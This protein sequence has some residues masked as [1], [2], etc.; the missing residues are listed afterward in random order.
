MT[1]HGNTAPIH[2]HKGT[3]QG[4]TLSLFLFTIF[5]EPLL[6]W[7]DVGSR[8][9]RPSYQPRKSTTIIIT[10]DDHGYVD[11]VSITAGSIQNL[12]IQLKNSASL[13][14]TPDSN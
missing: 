13:A 11:D 3:L 2:I 1:I 8:G 9:Y 14:N 7:L 6:R 10:H 12:K 5:M 4:D